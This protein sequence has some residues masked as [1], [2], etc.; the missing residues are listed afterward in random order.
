MFR[1]ADAIEKSLS[2]PRQASAPI[3]DHR[4]ASG[5][6]SPAI[7]LMTASL[8]TSA[9][10]MLGPRLGAQTWTATLYDLA[11]GEA[12]AD[13]Q[14]ECSDMTTGSRTTRTGSRARRNSRGATG[15]RPTRR[16]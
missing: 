10:Q 4:P 11:P 2:D 12:T 7:N 9:G 15:A 5:A 16:R 8:E 6:S 1:R 3:G 14:Y 13:Y